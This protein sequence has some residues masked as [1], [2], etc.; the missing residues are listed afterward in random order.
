MTSN[1]TPTTILMIPIV[2]SIS[3]KSTVTWWNFMMTS[4]TSLIARVRH[5]WN[6]SAKMQVFQTK[7]F[8]R[9]VFIKIDLMQFFKNIKVQIK[10]NKWIDYPIDLRLL[11]MFQILL[12][13]I[14]QVFLNLLINQARWVW[15]TT[16][17]ILTMLSCKLID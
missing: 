5:F 14:N 11:V 10:I 3:L 1:R 6:Y 7:E 12:N 15:I 16:K 2:I 17:M 8:K 9:L 13:L 4:M